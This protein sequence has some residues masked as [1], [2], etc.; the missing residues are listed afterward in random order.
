MITAWPLSLH[1]ALLAATTATATAATTTAS[2][3]RTEYTVAVDVDPQPIASMLQGN[4]DWGQVFNPTYVAPTSAT[5]GRGGLLIRSQN[6]TIPAGGGCGKGQIA[7]RGPGERASWL[8]WA[9][10]TDDHG[11]GAAPPQ[12]VGTVRKSSAVFG[13]FDC[14]NTSATTGVTTSTTSPTGT[15]CADAF[16][17]EDPRLTFDPE[18][19]LYYLLYNAYDGHN[20][21][22]SLATA[23]D[24]TSKSGWTR[25]GEL[26]PGAGLGGYK[27]G[28]IVLREAPG[29]HF[30]IWGCDRELRITPSIGRS[31]LHWDFNKSS[32]LLAV[33]KAP[34]YWDTGFV[35]S[36]MPP[37]TLSTGDLLFFYD[38]LGPWNG[39]S[40]FQPGWAVL[41]GKD[42]T[43]VIARAE[44]PPMPY[45]LPW[46]KG[47]APWPCNVAHV[48]NL[49]GGYAL[50]NDTFRVFFGGADS[51]VGTAMVRVEAAL[52]GS[53]TTQRTEDHQVVDGATTATAAAATNSALEPTCAFVLPNATGSARNTPANG[54]S[55]SKAKH[56]DPGHYVCAPPASLP[57][58]SSLVLMIPGLAAADY[59]LFAQTLAQAGRAVAVI[60]SEQCGSMC[61]C[62]GQPGAPAGALNC[63]DSSPAGTAAMEACGHAARTMHLIGD[64]GA[65]ADPAHYPSIRP[66]DSIQGRLEALLGYLGRGGSGRE[67]EA[68]DTND[69]AAAFPRGLRQLG[70][71][72][73][74]AGQL[75]WPAIIAAGHSCASYYPLL[76]ANRYPL[77]RVVLIGGVGGPLGAYNLSLTVPPS[78]MYGFVRSAD[79]ASVAP[80]SECGR[81][82]A[83]CKNATPPAIA[84]PG[85]SNTGRTCTFAANEAD[86]R[87]LR[88]PGQGAVTPAAV[89]AGAGAGG[90]AAFA[91]A[92]GGARQ[93]Y[94][95]GVCH[96]PGRPIMTH[97][98]DLCDLQ[99]HRASDGTPVLAP[100]WR[101]LVANTAAV[102]GPA[103]R[104]S[105][106]CNTS[107]P[108]WLL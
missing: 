55:A 24:P 78:E 21:K 37:L 89:T 95:L 84:A 65:I 59:T 63:S 90:D 20:V 13:P 83:A 97:L 101:Y 51:V 53:G 70:G 96:Y 60:S 76:L 52:R 5:G 15:T 6:C 72:L 102:T 82:C 46:E 68:V 14:P 18:T 4:S 99:T 58:A 42:P 16:G 22:L 39:T 31:L 36:A 86:Y 33:R 9:E 103:A 27:S 107:E 88:L 85:G 12:I 44:T 34:V 10:L 62:K 7:C 93:L 108:S 92:V 49:G 2:T 105:V 35:E 40:G 28:S 47:T 71:F 41:S 81:R 17:T 11:P 23:A 32:T 98:C 19:R 45:V 57:P 1:L 94:D 61:Y 91:A 38:S 8:T 80:G 25:H 67:E 26:F 48:S 3:Q 56:N 87:E 79:C 73:D 75:R 29:E 43:Q 64:G 50:G 30:V 74:G 104:D 100:V 66:E 106:T 69:L 77:S 54:N